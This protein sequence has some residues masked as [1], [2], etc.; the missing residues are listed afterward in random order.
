MGQDKTR[1]ALLIVVAVLSLAF[2]MLEALATGS[3]MD[4]HPGVGE[5]SRSEEPR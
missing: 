2:A 3:G 1:I 5:V 4:L